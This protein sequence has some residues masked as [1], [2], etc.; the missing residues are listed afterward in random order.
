M[1]AFHFGNTI[2]YKKRFHPDKE[3]PF[4]INECGHSICGSDYYV[5][6]N[7]TSYYTIEYIIS[8][9]GYV[10]E[11]DIISHPCAGDTHIFHPSLS[12][13][14]YAD[15][16]EPWEKVWIIFYGPAADALF[17]IYGL[18]KALCFHKLNLYEPIKKIIDLCDTDVLPDYEIM[19]KC[20]VIVFDMLQQ[21]YMYTIKNEM[22]LHRLSIAEKL[23]VL[24]D[25]MWDFSIT[26]DDLTKQL[27]CSRNHAIRLFSQKYNISPYKYIS[28]IRLRKARHILKDSDIPV[29]T[30]ARSLGF[31]DSHYFANWFKQRMKMTPTEYRA[32][33][34]TH[35]Q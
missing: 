28:Q 30:I 12:Q 21:L 19:S 27:Y 26:L 4:W 16:S 17:E 11:N 15:P 24:I 10:E 3:Y 1:E 35:I 23:K 25:N 2:E 31:C 33:Y 18:D 34:K 8:G 7:V 22:E 14:F 20:S 29:T 13:V 5:S 32:S 6:R 9:K